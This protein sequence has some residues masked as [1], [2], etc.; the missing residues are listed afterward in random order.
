MTKLP[1]EPERLRALTE[2]HLTLLVEAAAGTGKTALMAGRITMLLASAVE[3]R[4]V[5]A[6]TFTELAAS[7][8]GARVHRYVDDLLAGRVPKPLREA[9]AN[10]L[11][12]EQQ[13][14]LSVAARKLDELMV[15]TI[16]AFCQTIITATRSK[17]MSIRAPECS[18]RRRPKRLSRLR[19]SNGSE[20]G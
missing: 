3:P 9:L 19:S 20:G 10:G 18:T 14:A 4:L 11:T 5:T 1:D 13:R 6:I 16:H 8:L 17:P 12:A 2:L 15:T 7:A